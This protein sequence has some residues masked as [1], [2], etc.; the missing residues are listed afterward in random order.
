MSRIEE[1]DEQQILQ[2]QTDT[3]I[4]ESPKFK[5]G[6]AYYPFPDVAR[7]K[8]VPVIIQERIERGFQRIFKVSDGRTFTQD[9]LLTEKEI[10]GIK[11]MFKGKKFVN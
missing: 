7:G 11:K 10:P 6:E 8:D 1:T 4:S 3:D 2:E 5:V 9:Q